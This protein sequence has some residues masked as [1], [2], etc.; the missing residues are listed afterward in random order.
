MLILVST[1]FLLL[2]APWHICTISAQIIGYIANSAS[3]S[4]SSSSSLL[5]NSTFNT[6][7]DTYSSFTLTT[8][9]PISS[10]ESRTRSN[11][12]F[13]DIFYI[14][15]IITQH[16]SYLSYSINF[17]LY[18]FCGM[19]FRRELMKVLSRCRNYREHLPPSTTANFL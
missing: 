17:F 16:I 15:M 6:T 14:V 11:I 9:M 10:R 3:P 5:L 2:N 4:S 8:P 18:S 13:L 1:C 12:S 7:D 19:K